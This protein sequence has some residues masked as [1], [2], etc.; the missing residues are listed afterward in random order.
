MKNRRQAFQKILTS[1]GS[2]QAFTIENSAL[3]GF[4]SPASVTLWTDTR[5]FIWLNE[6]LYGPKINVSKK[7]TK[8]ISVS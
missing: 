5:E 6:F 8:L 3:D 2:A 1:P 4:T 7:T